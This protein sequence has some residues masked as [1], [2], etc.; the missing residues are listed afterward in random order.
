MHFQWLTIINLAVIYNLIVVIGRSVF[1]ELQSLSTNSWF[2]LDYL[3][4]FLYI[5]DIV[6]RMHEGNFFEERFS[7]FFFQYIITGYLEQ[8]LMVQDS[9][10]LRKNYLKSKYVF[11]NVISILPTDLA[12]L[13]IG[14][15]CYETM[16]CPVIVR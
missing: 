1:W 9:K 2:F 5:V 7:S 15:A 8:G 14:H 13:F 10:K 11:L 12:Y 6:V 16:P 4:D 3:C